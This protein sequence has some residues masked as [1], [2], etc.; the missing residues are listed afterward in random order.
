LP[1][2][3]SYQTFINNTALTQSIF[4]DSWKLAKI[5]LIPKSAIEYSPISVLLYLSKVFERLMAGQVTNYLI[6]NIINILILADKQSG[7]RV[8]SY[9]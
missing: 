3:L 6:S 8:G 9:K 2:E 5:I 1:K 4:P 7:F